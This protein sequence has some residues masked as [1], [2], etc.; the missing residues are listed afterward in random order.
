MA[1][2]SP[3]WCRAPICRRDCRSKGCR[4]AAGSCAIAAAHRGF[5]TTGL[6]PTLI[7]D[8]PEKMKAALAAVDEVMDS[9][10]GVLGIHLEGPFLS[11]QKPGVHAVKHIRAPTPEDV[12][13]LTA[14]RK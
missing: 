10:P 1:R 4:T 9:E 3:R 6:L 5:G 2:R 14:R 12:A 7:T 11:P 8:T 13:L